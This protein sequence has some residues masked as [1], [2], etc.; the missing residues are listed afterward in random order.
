MVTAGLLADAVDANI[1]RV[2]ATAGPIDNFILEQ[3]VGA[4][5]FDSAIQTTTILHADCFPTKI[6]INDKKKRDDTS[7]VSGRM[8]R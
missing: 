2:R 6:K 5:L 1:V 4:R 8:A 7:L 3:V